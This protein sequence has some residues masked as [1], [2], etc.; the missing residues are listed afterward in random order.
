ME[1]RFSCD[2]GYKLDLKVAEML[3]KYGFTGIFYI[4]LINRELSNDE[5]K[6]LSKKHEI[7]GHTKHHLRLT[8][9]TEEIQKIEIEQGKQELEEIIGKNITKFCYVRGWFNETTKRLVKEAGF[10]EARTMKF[11]ITDITGY[12]KYELPITA[13]LRPRDEYKKGIVDSILDLFEKSK[14][15]DGYFNLILHSWEVEKYNLW[16]QLDT[17][18]NKIYE[19][20]STRN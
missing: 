16:E 4:P 12:D 2:D 3:E 5:I 10:E 18:L 20:I 1:L 13:H 19:S 15:E 8:K 7:G 6:E 9:Y 11:G 17:I 14:K